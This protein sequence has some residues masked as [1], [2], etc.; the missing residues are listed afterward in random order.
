MSNEEEFLK[1]LDKRMDDFANRVFQLSQENL[2]NDEKIDTGNLLKTGNINREFLKKT[3]VYPANYADSVEYGRNAGTMPPVAPLQKW[4]RR[5]L[6]LADKKA[7]QVGW[8]IAM[9]IKNR[10]IMPS[11]YLQPAIMQARAEFGI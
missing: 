5:K 4:A 7:D 10:G 2:V 8:A 9:S 11:P 3:I 1:A 6:G